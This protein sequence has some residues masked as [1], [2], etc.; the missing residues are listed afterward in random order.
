MDSKELVSETVKPGLAKTDEEVEVGRLDKAEVDV[1][2]VDTN[3][4]FSY[5]SHRSPFPEG[6]GKGVR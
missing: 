6:E 5:E 1:D 3:E 2:E 4:E